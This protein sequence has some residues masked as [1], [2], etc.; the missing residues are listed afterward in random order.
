MRPAFGAPQERIVPNLTGL[1][2][3]GVTYTISAMAIRK[4]QLQIGRARF[5]RLLD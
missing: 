3:E 4:P 2:D 1:L 5:Y